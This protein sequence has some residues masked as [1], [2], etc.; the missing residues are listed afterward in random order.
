[1]N[2]VCYSS[3]TFGYLN[4]ARVLFESVKRF[5]PDWHCVA[6]IT[7]VPPAGF[8]W[9]DDESIDEIVYAKDLGI[10]NFETWLFKLDVIEVCTAVKGPYL[11]QACKGNADAVVY[12]DPDTCL[13]NALDPLI[14]EL[15][16]SE[17]VITPHQIYPDKER[18]A[19]IDNEITSLKTGIYNLGFLAVRTTGE[20]QR[21]AQWWSDRLLEFCHDDIPN[22]LFVDQRWCDHIPSFFENVKI[23]K[24]PGYN[25]ASWNLS[26]RTVDIDRDGV[27][28]V[29]GVPLRFWHFT[30]LGPLGDIMTKRYALDNFPVYELWA[31]YRDQ[32]ALATGMDV[33]HGYW[34]FGFYDDGAAI[35]KD[36]R[37]LYRHRKDL[38]KAF[39]NPYAS[40]D[41]TLQSWLSNEG[42]A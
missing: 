37:V 18:S 19:I 1:M 42:V 31:W 35:S 33:P 21:M 41:G 12:L 4:R 30:K 40:G 34:A 32:V 6:L 7:D 27:A 10:E 8:Q 38:Q 39:P 17:I 29:N 28:H 24:D 13:F 25:V 9:R 15:Q 5:H 36:Q 16:R 20:G 14:E 22:G 23:L 11:L 26:H 2:V 3:F